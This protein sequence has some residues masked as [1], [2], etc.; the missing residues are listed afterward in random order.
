MAVTQTGRGIWIRNYTR[1]DQKSIHTLDKPALLVCFSDPRS[2]FKRQG[3]L[4][5]VR[6]ASPLE[7]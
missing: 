4:W 6:T 2:M 7:G 5:F 3:C 1:D